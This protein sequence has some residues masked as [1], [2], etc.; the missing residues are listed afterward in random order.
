[1]TAFAFAR[2]PDTF[3]V[4]LR[5]IKRHVLSPLFNVDQ[6][7]DGNYQDLFARLQSK[8]TVQSGFLIT[9]VPCGKEATLVFS[10]RVLQVGNDSGRQN[11]TNKSG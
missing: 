7:L 9:K 8:T 4:F 11:L 3:A 1:V 10:K 5:F 2:F 6:D